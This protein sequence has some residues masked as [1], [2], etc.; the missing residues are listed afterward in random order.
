VIFASVPV[1]VANRIRNQMQI[2][3]T[4]RVAYSFLIGTT[5]E[6]EQKLS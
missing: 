2:N 3:A 6:E 4:V 5:T 1:S